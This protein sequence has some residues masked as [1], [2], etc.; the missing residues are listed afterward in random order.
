MS[1]DSHPDPLNV[2]IVNPMGGEGWGGVE[3]WLVDV[4]DGLKGRGHQVLV[5]GRPG[6]KWIERTAAAGYETLARVDV[7]PWSMARTVPVMG[8]SSP[9]V[10]P[11]GGLA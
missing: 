9:M 3:R 1:A 11:F 10:F 8:V 2:L 7:V 4:S 6:S 5:S